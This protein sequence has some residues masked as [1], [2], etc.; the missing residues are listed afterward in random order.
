MRNKTKKGNKSLDFEIVFFEKLI[1]DKPDFTDA[2]IPLAELYTKSGRYKEGLSL[3]IRLSKLRPG[4][5]TV[6]YNMACSYSLLGKIDEAISTLKQAVRLGY[7]DFQ[8]MC[9]D[10][11][12]LNLKEDQRYRKFVAKIA[13]NNQARESK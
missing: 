8:Y 7:S 13:H 1:N 5:S 2:L 3:D 9:N 6:Y 4:D 12:F 10:P 11:D